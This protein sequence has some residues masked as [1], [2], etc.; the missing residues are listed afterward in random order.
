MCKRSLHFRPQQWYTRGT[1]YLCITDTAAVVDVTSAAHVT[2]FHDQ[3][4]L[5]PRCCSGYCLYMESQGCHRS[6]AALAFSGESSVI[7]GL[8]VP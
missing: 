7:P 4:L 1:C 5:V 6:E 8:Y 2:F 3:S